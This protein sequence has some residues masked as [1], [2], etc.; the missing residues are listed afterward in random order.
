MKFSFSFTTPF[1]TY[2]GIFCVEQIWR[3]LKLNFRTNQAIWLH[4]KS[5]SFEKCP[6]HFNVDV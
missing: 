1:A 3:T 2:N 4:V 5:H 6:C